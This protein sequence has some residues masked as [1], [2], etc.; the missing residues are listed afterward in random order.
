M[1]GLKVLF[2]NP[3]WKKTT[4]CWP[5]SYLHIGLIFCLSGEELFGS[6]VYK[7][8]KILVLVLDDLNEDLLLSSTVS[9]LLTETVIDLVGDL[10]NV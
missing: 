10:H 4:F 6:K 9:G 8:D 5:T 2:Y 3:G 1:G 7:P